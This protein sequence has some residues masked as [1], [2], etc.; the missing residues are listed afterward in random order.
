MKSSL[1]KA[2]FV[3][4]ISLT[5]CKLSSAQ[6]TNIFPADGNVGIG[7]TT[8]THRLTIDG[9][10]KLHSAGMGYLI[11][12]ATLS[13]TKSGAST[14]LG[15]NI[16]AGGGSN[17]IQRFNNPS[18]P[19]SFVALNYS[20]GI[21]FH[22]GVASDLGSDAPIEDNEVMRIRH[23]GNVGIGTINPGNYKLAVNGSIRAREIKVEV[24]NWPDF[25]FTKSY[26]LP[27]LQETEKHIND[28]GHL[29][30]IPSAEEVKTNGIH[31]GEMNAKLLQKIEE[32]TL[33]LIEQSKLTIK[34]KEELT[35]QRLLLQKMQSEINLLKQTKRDN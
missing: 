4:I 15:N 9:D 30:G 6:T 10:V 11:N 14:V 23:D 33:H 21:T 7:T 35:S 28:K 29:L 27:T 32:L 25:V 19:G 16:K 31:L 18:D 17:T 12:Y 2:T 13:E 1:I 5:L 20:Y 24:A 3:G 22:T 34:Q 8:P 26:P